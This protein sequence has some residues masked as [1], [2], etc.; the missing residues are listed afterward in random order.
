MPYCSSILRLVFVNRAPRA[1]IAKT[2]NNQSQGPKT[3]LLK[4]LHSYLISKYQWEGQALRFK[5][6]TFKPCHVFCQLSASEKGHKQVRCLFLQASIYLLGLCKHNCPYLSCSSH[7]SFH[8][9]IKLQKHGL[10]SGIR[11]LLSKAISYIG[12]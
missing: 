9:D 2:N 10:H 11:L 1:L 7:L 12:P 6:S 3:T 5:A 4:A 8:S